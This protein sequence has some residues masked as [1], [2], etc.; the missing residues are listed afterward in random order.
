MTDNQKR[1]YSETLSAF[2]V[3][4]EHANAPSSAGVTQAGLERMARFACE[5]NDLEADSSLGGDGQ[6]FLWMEYLETLVKPMLAIAQHEGGRGEAGLSEALHGSISDADFAAAE[7]MMTGRHPPATRPA[8]LVEDEVEALLGQI[9]KEVNGPPG[10]PDNRRQMLRRAD[11]IITQQA[12]E[13]ARLREALKPY[14]NAPCTC[15][16]SPSNKC[17]SC[18]ARAALNEQPGGEG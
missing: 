1:E 14:S 18:C 16:R 12:E 7:A 5:W 17:Y 10:S 11:K 8:A 13:V 2:D 3:M 4:A 9:D 15:S 6:N